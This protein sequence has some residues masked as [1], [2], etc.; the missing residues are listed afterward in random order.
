MA[1]GRDFRGE[2]RVTDT[3][4]VEHWDSQSIIDAQRRIVN[5]LRR[6]HGRVLDEAVAA[7]A[8]AASVYRQAHQ[9]AFARSRIEDP[10]AAVKVHEVAAD[11]A[12]EAQRREWELAKLNRRVLFERLES[13]RAELS[14][15]QSALRETSALSRG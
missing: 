9:A 3:R 7:E 6:L 13:C 5:E 1:L 2:G 11:A 8:D 12:A 10:K 15:C 14:A 4:P